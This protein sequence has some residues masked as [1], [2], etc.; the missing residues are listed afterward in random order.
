MRQRLVA[1]FLTSFAVA[2]CGADGPYH[3][4]FDAA[5]GDAPVNPP[6]D[7][8]TDAAS[9]DAS[10]DTSAPPH[11]GGVVT[12]MITIPAGAF[13]RGCNPDNDNK[14]QCT[15]SQLDDEIPYESVT[16]S[17]Y[18]IDL[19][20]V[21]QE[22]Y[23]ECVAAGACT[24]PSAVPG[25][26]QEDAGYDPT[27]KPDHPVSNIS[28][29]QARTYCLWRSK[30]LPTEAEWENA[31]RGADGRTY[32]W[33]D[34][35]VTCDRANLGLCTGSGTHAVATHPDGASIYGVLDMAGNVM[36]WVN[37]FYDETYYQTAPTTDPQGPASGSHRV[38]RGGGFPHS[39]F[40]ARVAGR[41]RYAAA[42]Y[43]L[44]FRCAR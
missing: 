25:K 29:A 18:E 16:L 35:V 32:P 40:S 41:S 6:I 2:A 11:D 42:D 17:E 1:L 4:P 21:V 14:Y 7:G 26:L 31:A 5:V 30:R 8:S 38:V 13:M 37:D 36:E 39:S 12:D 44:G 22:A 34:S 10:T 43:A 28:W 24:L 19:T 23:A 33:G 15:D 3:L 20:E 27:V 9:L